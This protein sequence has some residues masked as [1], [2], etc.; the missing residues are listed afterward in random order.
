[1]NGLIENQIKDF[2]EKIRKINSLEQTLKDKIGNLDLMVFDKEKILL[3]GFFKDN[4]IQNII[5]NISG[6]NEFL[7]NKIQT[8]NQKLEEIKKDVKHKLEEELKDKLKKNFQFQNHINEKIKEI[9]TNINEVIN[10]IKTKV[11]KK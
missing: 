1:M 11:M 6:S 5:K 8:I 9:K 2:D 3:H 7:N 4:N 10:K